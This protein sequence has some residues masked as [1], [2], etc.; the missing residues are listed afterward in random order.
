MRQ[1]DFK[2]NE[3]ASLSSDPTVAII[4]YGTAGVNALIALRTHGYEG[5]VIVFSDTDTLPY[6]PILTSYY[7]GG[8]KPY[9]AVFPWSSEELD[10]LGAEVHFDCPV[11][12]LDPET[13]T[14][15]TPEGDF[16]YTKCIIASGAKAH[17]AGFPQFEGFSP[18]VLR[19]LDEAE[20]LKQALLDPACK[21]ILISGAS[22]IALK[23][24]E[25]CLNRDIDTTLVGM[26]PHVLDFNAFPETAIRVEAAL[27][28]YG[29][30]LRLGMVIKKVRYA[31]EAD[32]AKGRLEVTFS[33]GD[34]D[35]FDNIIVAHG[36]RSSLAFL[37]KDALELDRALVVDE[38]MRTSDPDIYAAGDV[39]QA[40]ELTSGEKRIVG[41]WKSAALQG[42]CA[43]E[44]IAA[45][46]T[47]K[48][49]HEAAVYPGAV[50]TNTIVIRDTL[51][52]SAG[53]LELNEKRHTESREVDDMLIMTVIEEDDQGNRYLVGFNIA[54]D[55]DERGGDAYDLG[56]MLTMQIE[57]D[58]E[59]RFPPTI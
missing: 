36:V 10:S 4:G 31:D 12:K 49:I 40:F 37:E 51:F 44:A 13:H 22:M 14:I 38:H 21:R 11:T 17:C 6:S 23:A 2:N 43:G 3:H 41:I 56:A 45:E 50:A 35:F 46:L 25:A 57:Q 8:M 52:I 19:T 16:A 47:G 54:C 29:M 7:A 27:R 33:N 42:A 15:S 24:A 28:D 5:R 1:L 26:N 18:L 32:A 9:E 30:T 55:H 53:T 59:K 48:G 34:V 20:R 39:A 58:S